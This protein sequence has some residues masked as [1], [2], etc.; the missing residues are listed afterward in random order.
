MWFLRSSFSHVC[1]IKNIL[2]EVHQWAQGD[3]NP[4]G[5]TKEVKKSLFYYFLITMTRI[6]LLKVTGISPLNENIFLDLEFSGSHV[7]DRPIPDSLTVALPSDNT[8]PFLITDESDILISTSHD[9]YELSSI[10]DGVSRTNE[11]QRFKTSEKNAESQVSVN[12]PST[13][14]IS[15]EEI[16]TFPKAGPR[17]ENKKNIRKRKSTIYTDTPEKENIKELK[18]KQQLPKVEVKEKEKT[19]HER[20]KRNDEDESEEDE[21]FSLECTESYSLSIHGEEWIQCITCKLWIHAKVAKGNLLF[22][23]CKNCT[24]DLED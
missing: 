13:S 19:L 11:D 18:I 15:P 17:L 16:R 4:S 12:M 10:L 20:N 3:V 23:E 6:C 9:F 24:F 21:T 7:T 1:T 22:Y 5:W 8:F 2:L 14:F